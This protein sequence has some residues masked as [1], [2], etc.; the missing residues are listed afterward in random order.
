MITFKLFFRFNRICEMLGTF[1]LNEE[2]SKV[3]IDS[4]ETA[5]VA[6]NEGEKSNRGGL[7]DRGGFFDSLGDRGI[8]L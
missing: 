3:C 5:F 7:G 1:S 2:N 8:E 6:D 4:A